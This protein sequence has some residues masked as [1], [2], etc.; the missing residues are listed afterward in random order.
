LASKSRY[1]PRSSR[2]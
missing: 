2:F 1:F